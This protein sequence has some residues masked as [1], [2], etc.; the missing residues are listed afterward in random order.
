MLELWCRDIPQGWAFHGPLICALCP[1]M[2]FCDDICSL[3]R[4][5]SLMMGSWGYRNKVYNVVVV[6]DFFLRSMTSLVSRIW[7]VFS[8]NPCV[9]WIYYL[10]LTCKCHFWYFLFCH[11]G[12]CG[13]IIMYQC[14]FLIETKF[15][16]SK[17]CWL[18]YPMFVLKIRTHGKYLCH[19]FIF[20]STWKFYKS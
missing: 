8:M 2:V 14:G 4:E 19:L 13:Y 15:H 17:E 3:Q 12:H 18:V 20:L 7:L 10:S 5:A 6:V 9:E 11:A 1:A 16:S